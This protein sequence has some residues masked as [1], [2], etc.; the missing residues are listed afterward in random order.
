M[1]QTAKFPAT[2]TRRKPKITGPT[3]GASRFAGALHLW[4]PLDTLGALSLSKRRQTPRGE[5][6]GWCSDRLGSRRLADFC[7]PLKSANRGKQEKRTAEPST[8]R[9]APTATA[10]APTAIGRLS[11]HIY[12][13]GCRVAGH[14]A[15]DIGDNDAVASRIA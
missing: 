12:R 1:P 13:E 7:P 3:E 6:A 11:H 4:L 9:T 2:R 15:H 14:A 10:A 5:N 8:R